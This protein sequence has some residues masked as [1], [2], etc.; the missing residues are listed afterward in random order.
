MTQRKQETLV[1]FGSNGSS[2]DLL[3][4]SADKYV[5]N[6]NTFPHICINRQFKLINF[7]I[8]VPSVPL[9]TKNL[10]ISHYRRYVK[11]GKYCLKGG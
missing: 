10:S 9:V 11:E 7:L 2:G 8:G 5:L 6:L 4:S 3:L 1:L